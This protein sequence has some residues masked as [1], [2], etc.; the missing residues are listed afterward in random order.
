MFRRSDQAFPSSG[1][2]SVMNDIDDDRDDWQS[3]NSISRAITACLALG[4]AHVR[5]QFDTVLQDHRDCLVAGM[6]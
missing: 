1:D 4:V 6:R 2:R 5:R 3:H